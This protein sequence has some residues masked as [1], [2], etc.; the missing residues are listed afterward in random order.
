MHLVVFVDSHWD[1]F[2]PFSMIRPVFALASGATTLLRKNVRQVQPSRL[3]LWVRPE[4]VTFCRQR[5]TP[6]LGVATQVNVPLDDEPAVLVNGRTFFTGRPE[7]PSEQA[8]ALTNS[9]AIAMARVKSR[10]LSPG[11]A[12]GETDNWNKLSRLASIP[13]RGKLLESAVDLIYGN[14][15]SIVDDFAHHDGPSMPFETGPYHLVDELDIRLSPD[16]ALSPG[17]VL[18]ASKGP[19]IVSEGATIGANAVIQ[20]PCWIGPGSVI[21]PLANIRPGVSIGAMCKVGGEVS[22]S[23]FLGYSNKSHEGFLG[24]SYLGKWV[25]LGAGTTT[26]NLKNTYGPITLKRGSR[27]MT[28]DR[29]FLGALIG[30]H[31]KTAIQ[32]RL[33]AGSYIG[34]F[35]MLAGSTHAPRFIPSFSFW[36]DKG[37]VPYDREKAVEVAQRVYTRRDRAWT[38]ADEMLMAYV[39]DTAPRVEA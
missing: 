34:Y 13:F 31:T 38:E 33:M 36:T 8:V 1:S 26:S 3:T 7:I 5:L 14:D 9:G 2:A 20:G 17:C 18:D 32:T 27:E 15:Q 30:D 35:S 12:L 39:A 16:V 10:S 25:N 19:I 21:A 24:H 4:L 22:L 37:L 23:I 29:R 11:D 6:E 28:T